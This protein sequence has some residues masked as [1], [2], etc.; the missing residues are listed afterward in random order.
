MYIYK[1]IFTYTDCGVRVSI[2][3][4]GIAQRL[5]RMNFRF[6]T[7]LKLRVCQRLRCSRS[8][9]PEENMKLA[10][11]DKTN[12]CIVQFDMSIL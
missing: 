7:F 10:I 1:H 4:T 6:S 2:L 9:Q 11:N 5:R 8:S 3:C 12:A